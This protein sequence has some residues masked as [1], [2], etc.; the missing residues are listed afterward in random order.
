MKEPG[1]RWRGLVVTALVGLVWIAM[2]GGRWL[3][4]DAPQK[5]DVILVLAG[6]TDK[7]PERGLRLLQQEYATRMI[8]DVPAQARVYQW[9]Q[10]ELAQKY[11]SG[12]PQAAGLTACPVFGRSTQEEARDAEKCLQAAG[13]RSVL[14]VTSDFHTRRA[15]EIW[16]HE[17]PGYTMS[18]AAARDPEQFAEPWWQR[19]QWAKTFLAE[20]LKFLWWETV[21]RWR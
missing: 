10:M 17:L 18:V 8:L 3:V 5:S 15:L 9:S 14:M 19:R 21:D 13:A 7:R 6:E 2:N 16:R 12:L 20:G 11:L 1:R 4:I